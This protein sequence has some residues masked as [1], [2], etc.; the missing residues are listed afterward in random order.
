MIP[1][2]SFQS[3]VPMAAD[4]RVYLQRP[5]LT[6]LLEKAAQ[7]RIIIVTAGA[8][9]GKTQA[10][11]SFLQTHPVRT[12][13][14]QLSERD[15]FS[16]RFWE[17]FITA[18]SHV[19][20]GSA[21]KLEELGFPATDRQF[22]RYLNIPRDDV[23]P[24]V[25]YFFVYD[26][27]HLLTDKLVLRFME[28]SITSIFPN[29]TSILIS[30][31]DPPMNEMKMLSRNLLARI[32]EE[33]LR[34]SQKELAEYLSLQGLHPSPHTL[35]AVYRDTEGWA[36]AI[37]L[38]AL[39]L[40]NVPLG[41]EYAPAAIR[42]NIFK[43]IENEIIHT[44]SPETQKFLIKLSLIDHL[45][46]D[47]LEQIAGGGRRRNEGPAVPFPDIMNRT[48][49]FIQFDSYG[50]AYR[51]H[52]L[53]LD[54]LKT[55]QTELG[56]DEKKK[57]WAQTAAWC[58]QNG[59]KMDAISYYEK[60]GDYTKLI[61]TTY[62][63]PM[64]PPNKMAAFL[65]EIMNRAPAEIYEKHATAHITRTRLIMALGRFSEAE[66]ELRAVIKKYEA[67]PPSPFV[68]RA[69][70]GCY[71]NLGFAG[72]LTCPSTG[73]YNFAAFFEKARHYQALCGVKVT[74]TLTIAPISS[75]ICRVGKNKKGEIE[76]YIEAISHTVEHLMASLGGCMAGNDDL[77]RG[78]LALFRAEIDLS[79]QYCLQAL[80]KARQ[81]NQYDIENRCLFFLL[82]TQIC[83]GNLSGIRNILKEL[84]DQLE[85]SDHLTSHAYYDIVS[86]WF[87]VQTGQHEKLAP[88]LKSVLEESDL[89]SLCS[90]LEVL[91]KAK[92]HFAEKHWPTVLATLKGGEYSYAG[93]FL[94]GRLEM[95]ALEAVCRYQMNDKTRAFAALKDAYEL[96]LPNGLFLPF[97]ELGK[98]MRT[99][100]AAA[101][102]AGVPG[103]PPE[104]LEEANRNAA[105]YGKKLYAVIETFTN[106]ARGR[107]AAQT[108][109]PLSRREQE[110]LV[111]L[112]RGFTREE[113]AADLDLSINTV[114]SVIKSIY[115]KL[116]AINRADAI[117]IAGSLG[118]LKNS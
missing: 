96:A 1:D 89:N 46:P 67:L 6:A 49:S 47:L 25:K 86:G 43:L 60:T 37:H 11:Y 50:N 95:K 72:M 71:T 63:L 116:G 15:N 69:L 62:T 83:K 57:V 101:R 61:E 84:S 105:S 28:H 5:H 24:G 102:V 42:A 30:R 75:Y 107:A 87:Y 31:T 20:T 12:V 44:L 106:S 54:Y 110:L 38:A 118:I 93:K 114:K 88:W 27:F 14:V 117:R 64:V 109:V 56:D 104:W 51:V 108:V 17:N 82:R 66:E 55:R 41:M 48:G 77:A 21:R 9:Y 39:S 73:N 16:D 53:F 78:E 7:K 3:N 81:Y 79:E 36:F 94:F 10:V 29:I 33:D 34:F 19:N 99:L 112:S 58:A 35:A 70:S 98:D 13:W 59:R 4:R 90:G 2:G 80:Q 40:R 97:T 92:Y 103:I 111:D 85:K 74:G 52:H 26:D 115:N 100:S 8:G 18:V 91:V 113:I 76:N 65:L 23:I 32:T 22:D 68:H 45:A